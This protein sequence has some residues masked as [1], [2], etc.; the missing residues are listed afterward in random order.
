MVHNLHISFTSFRNE[1]RLLKETTSLLAADTIQSVSIACL[2]E[3]GLQKFEK[4]ISG[5]KVY[6][7]PLASRRIPRSYLTYFLIYFEFFVRVIYLCVKER[8]SII[9]IHAISI[10]PIGVALKLIFRSRLVYETHELETETVGLAGR[11]K[12]LAKWIEARLI[13]FC[14]LTVVVSE[15]IANWYKQAYRAQNVITV[16]NC[17]LASRPQKAD[18]FRDKLGISSDVKIAL[19]QG[20]I[21]KGRNIPALV[22][23]GRLLSDKGW[24]VVFMGYGPLEKT[25]RAAAAETKGVYFF[26]AVPPSEILAY[27][28]SADVGLCLIEDVCLSYHFS[29]PNKF[30]EYIM[31][32]VPAISSDL[33]EMSKINREYNIGISAKSSSAADIA[34]A[35]LDSARLFDDGTPAR[36][37]KAAE[38]YCWENQETALIA[39]Y[40]DL[41]PHS[42]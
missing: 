33:P 35:V 32:R 12:Q 42:R 28:S 31:A 15:S 41:L 23:A 1:S 6:R 24:I 7:F 19:Y 30:F 17:P 22:E 39:A 27:T 2:H 25:V 14:D 10:L 40:R 18:K 13:G 20:G 5:Q 9:S 26:P 29:L 21:T 4:L 36:L 16:M 8:P 37:D 34:Q 38:K 3:A 11:R